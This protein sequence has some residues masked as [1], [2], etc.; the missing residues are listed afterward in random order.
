M[1]VARVLG[2]IAA[3]GDHQ[4]D[5]IADEAHAVGGQRRE[6]GLRMAGQHLEA[7]RIGHLLQVGAGQHRDAPGMRARRDVDVG[8]PRVCTGCARTRRAASRA[9]TTSST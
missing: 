4:D 9:R 6:G 1:S 8:D 3:L 7:H 5:R 2:E